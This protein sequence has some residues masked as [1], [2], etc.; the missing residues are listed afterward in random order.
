M[1][2]IVLSSEKELIL[3][4]AMLTDWLGWH[5]WQ[6]WFCCRA[7]CCWCQHWVSE[8]CEYNTAIVQALLVPEIS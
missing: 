4:V 3:L 8:W 2:W 6:L 7:S 1:Q 5:W